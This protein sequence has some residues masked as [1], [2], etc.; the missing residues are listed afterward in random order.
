MRDGSLGVAIVGGGFAAASHLD[1]L[2][3]V[4]G[5]TP[6]G[7]LTSSP[8]R[9]REAAERL[10]VERAYGALD[11]LLADADIDVIH[12]CTPN[13]LHHAITGAAL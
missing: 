13:H 11:D 12:N 8:E 9:S 6:L 2:R 10:G 5:V 4:E 7:V 3:R 1:A